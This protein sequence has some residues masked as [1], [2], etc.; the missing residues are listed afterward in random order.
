MYQVDNDSTTTIDGENILFR[1]MIRVEGNVMEIFHHDDDDADIIPVRVPLGKVMKYDDDTI[2]IMQLVVH[3]QDKYKMILFTYDEVLILFTYAT[4]GEL[5]LLFRVQLT[6]II[7]SKE[8]RNDSINDSRKNG[9]TKPVNSTFP[10]DN[11]NKSIGNVI[12]TK[13]LTDG[14]LDSN[15]TTTGMYTIKNTA[16]IVTATTSTTTVRRTLSRIPPSLA[17]SYSAI[18]TD[19]EWILLFRLA[20]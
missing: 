16:T 9:G 1:S 11:G 13:N 7:S 17:P 5:I 6:L 18:T 2:A 14:Y 15:T 10:T 4:D 19:G 3:Y 20:Y 12:V 8:D